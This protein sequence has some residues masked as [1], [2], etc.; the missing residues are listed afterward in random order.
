[1]D[2]WELSLMYLGNG[3]ANNINA[4]CIRFLQ[5][6]KE[7]HDKNLHRNVMYVS[8][9]CFSSLSALDLILF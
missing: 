3:S 5:G 2:L 4:N 9:T 6:K 7:D 1:M 8:G